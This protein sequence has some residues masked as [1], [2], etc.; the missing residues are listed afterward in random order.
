MCQAVS[1]YVLEKNLKIV[2]SDKT[3]SHLGIATEFNLRA[4]D[5]PRELLTYA[6]AE[7][8]PRR[9]KSLLSENPAG[10]DLVCDEQRRPDWW[11]AEFIKID[12]L[13]TIIP[14]IRAG[15]YGAGWAEDVDLRGCTSLTTL[16][17]GF[18]PGGNVDLGGCTSLTTLP[19]GFNPGGYVSLR[20]CTS[21][22]TLPEGFN[23]GGY[24]SLGG[25]TSLTTLPEGLDVD[26]IR[27]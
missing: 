1:F 14:L 10:W 13:N 2:I 19:E 6:K 23:P 9:A 17:E 25:C 16:P 8:I 5:R 7:L 21:L 15:R 4:D 11:D 26:K 27:R 22:T 3:D 18:N 12:A 20:G 24:V